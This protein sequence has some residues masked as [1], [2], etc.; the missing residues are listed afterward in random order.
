MNK[1]KNKD[2]IDVSKVA[3]MPIKSDSVNATQSKWEENLAKKIKN[4]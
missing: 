1:E 3:P 2:N 4:F